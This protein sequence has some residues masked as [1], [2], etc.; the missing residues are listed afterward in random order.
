MLFKYNC[1][2]RGEAGAGRRE[3][4]KEKKDQGQD[5]IASLCLQA[6]KKKETN[7]V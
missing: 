6:R 7:E 3:E 5:L 4:E 1:G 2:L